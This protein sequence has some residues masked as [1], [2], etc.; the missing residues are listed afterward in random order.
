[1]ISLTQEGLIV[2]SQTFGYFLG[3]RGIM[4]AIKGKDVG[5]DGNDGLW[6]GL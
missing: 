3:G 5:N 6:Y 4:I 2:F 1:M